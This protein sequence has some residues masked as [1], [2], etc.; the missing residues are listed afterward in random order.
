LNVTTRRGA[1]S[2]GSLLCGFLP[3]RAFCRGG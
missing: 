1:I 2:V 3:G